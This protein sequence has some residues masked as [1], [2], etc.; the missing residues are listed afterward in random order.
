MSFK[1][2]KG[3]YGERIITI[4]DV[5]GDIDLLIILLRDLAEIIKLH[6]GF[7]DDQEKSE[8]LIEAPRVDSNGNIIGSSSYDHMF[9]YEIINQ[10][11][12]TKIVL[13]G[14]YI[15][16][17]RTFQDTSIT[18]YEPLLNFPNS[19]IKILLF[20]NSLIELS[21]PQTNIQITKL[22]GNHEFNA[23]STYGISTYVG[24]PYDKYMGQNRNMYFI[25]PI[26]WKL[27]DELNKKNDQEFGTAYPILIK[28][29]KFIEKI[30]KKIFVHG[31]LPFKTEIN[32][33]LLTLTDILDFD[34]INEFN[35]QMIQ[36]LNNIPVTDLF[37][38]FASKHGIKLANII[39]Q[40][41]VSNS[42][43]LHTFLMGSRELGGLLTNRDLSLVHEGSC[44]QLHKN[45]QFL[46]KYQIIVAHTPNQLANNN[47]IISLQ[48]TPHV[49]T[50]EN[51]NEF[52]GDIQYNNRIKPEHN[53]ETIVNMTKNIP[54]FGISLDC[55][56]KIINV[57]CSM[58]RAFDSFNISYKQKNDTVINL[59]QKYYKLTDDELIDIIFKCNLMEL[60]T[61]MLVEILTFM[62]LVDLTQRLPQLIII[63][64]KEDD[65]GSDYQNYNIR[66]L[67]FI[68]TLELLPRLRIM[69]IPFFSF[70][71]YLALFEQF[72]IKLGNKFD[73]SFGLTVEYRKK[74][75][76][77]K[78]KVQ[79]I[80]H[81]TINKIKQQYIDLR[82]IIVLLEK[83]YDQ[84]NNKE[85]FDENYE[86]YTT[87][88]RTMLDLYYQ[89]K[90]NPIFKI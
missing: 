38:R 73:D 63:Q 13:M 61:N 27:N 72:E 51:Y 56:G 80:D 10:P 6:V 5:H 14:D 74:L 79:T 34:K 8:R 4:G 60:N 42:Q 90:N 69:A 41:Q 25:A 47:N 16:S 3:G 83:L 65:N 59:L 15:D 19:E 50:N 86:I 33:N 24:N 18:S 82:N 40:T 49:S 29:A 21:L 9:G 55:K 52:T 11:V 2:Q 43:V 54:Y 70:F 88:Y 39:K 77:Y 66:K 48:L 68:R 64:N 44:E 20:I 76:Q 31:G 36:L 1:E 46:T 22:L 26:Y 58:S 75:E 87:Q 71:F 89:L 23:M 78:A 85:M 32:N 57:D 81:D 7:G 12:V 35:Q 30:D 17:R 53:T 28:H 67:K 62:P 37:T 84:K 45:A